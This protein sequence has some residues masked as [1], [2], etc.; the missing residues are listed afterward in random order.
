MAQWGVSGAPGS[1]ERGAQTH[2]LQAYLGASWS[3]LHESCK[4][5]TITTIGVYTRGFIF[6]P[7]G[8]KRDSNDRL[9]MLNS[10]FVTF[11][12]FRSSP[13]VGGQ[14]CCVYN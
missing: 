12:C 2:P 3:L 7:L 1:P 13:A 5:I 11:G 4:F 6:I 9:G 14:V 10:A 8:T